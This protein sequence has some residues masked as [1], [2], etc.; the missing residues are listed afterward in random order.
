MQLKVCL[1]MRLQQ[2]LLLVASHCDIL[3]VIYRVVMSLNICRKIAFQHKHHETFLDYI[4]SLFRKPQSFRIVNYFPDSLK[5]SSLQKYLSNLIT[6]CFVALNQK[7][8]VYSYKMVQLRLMSEQNN[9]KN[10]HKDSLS[11]TIMA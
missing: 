5:W 3:T 11:P 4:Y 2:C 6:N 1:H 10:Q 8:K 9:T 7:K